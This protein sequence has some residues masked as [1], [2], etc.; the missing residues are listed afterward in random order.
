MKQ[1]IDD[2]YTEVWQLAEQ[3]GVTEDF[4]RRADYIY[5]CEGLIE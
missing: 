4:I 2:G 3:F 5:R 1:A